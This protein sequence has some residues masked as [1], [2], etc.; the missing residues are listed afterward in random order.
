MVLELRG[1]RAV[2]GPVAGVVRPHRQLVDQDPSVGGLEEL[3]GEDAGHVERA[4]DA[5]RDLLGLAGQRGVE[6][7]RRGD[8]LAADAVD[9]RGA[10]RRGTPRPGRSGERATS[11][12]S[13]RR[14]STS[15][16]ASSPT[17]AASA[18]PRTA[19][20]TPH[21]RATTQTPLPS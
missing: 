14:K 8:H 10:P 21:R 13:S 2:L 12:D 7:R 15:S 20:R 3:D 9:L 19:R 4:G 1:H 16:S 6:V 11:A 17:P 5:Q 18:A